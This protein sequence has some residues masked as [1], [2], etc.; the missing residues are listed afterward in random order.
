MLAV[1]FV[2]VTNALDPALLPRFVFLSLALL[3][4][5]IL[6][7]VDYFTRRRPFDMTFLRAAI[8]PALLGY[9]AVSAASLTQS[10][11]IADGLFDLLRSSLFAMALLALTWLLVIR[12][13]YIR[14]LCRT[15]AVVA[16]CLSSIAVLQYFDF[17]FRTIPGN[18]IPYATMA[19]KNL[20]ASFL[21]LSL[22]Y[23]I[24]SWL[25]SE[26]VWKYA[27]LLSIAL[28]MYVIGISHT[29]AVWL[30]LLTAGTLTMSLAAVSRVSGGRRAIA[31]FSHLHGSRLMVTALVVAIVAS[32][33]TQLS[34]TVNE[35][36]RNSELTGVLNAT[37]LKQRLALW[38]KTLK[39]YSD[40]PV[41]GTGVGD[42]K[43]EIAKY[44][45]E[46]LPSSTGGVFFQRPH[47]DF[48]WI[49]AETGPAGLGFYLSIFIIALYYCVKCIRKATSHD[50][51]QLSLLMFFG[52]IAFLVVSFF[53][54]PRERVA[55]ML[56]IAFNVAVTISLC[57]RNRLSDHGLSTKSLIVLFAAVNLSLLACVWIGLQRYKTEIHARNAIAAKVAGDWNRV[58][59]EVD[60]AESPF[61]K[62]DATST[63]LIWYRGVA[64]FNL[65]NVDAACDD[66]LQ[67]YRENPYHIHVLNNLGTCYETKGDHGAAIEFYKK[68]LEIIPTFEE[69][70]VNL[71]AVYYNTHDYQKAYTCLLRIKGNPTD[72]RY[73]T[74][75]QKITEKLNET[76]PD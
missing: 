7:Q 12:K 64:N 55:H 26:S 1:P 63:P 73:D 2:L 46:G 40:H 68:A 36:P 42:W 54:F 4:A 29:R 9:L 33:A 31:S 28:S 20:M 11:D 19:N 47:N 72:P 23:A 74:F 65:D 21:L 3:A 61:S 56:I 13:E 48:L 37:S 16:F 71:A 60:Q 62:F 41:L 8:F 27:S 18:V 6:L 45:A 75:M 38:D 66:F 44:G 58:I 17:G 5:L 14:R 76:E 69:T 59:S 35:P 50:D 24:Y 15:L 30:A 34:Y 52:L 25:R 57:H 39:M 53:S 43:I 22:P 32:I 70:L 51:T 67:A 49:L 10:L